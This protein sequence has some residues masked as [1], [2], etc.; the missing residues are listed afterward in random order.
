MKL[1]IVLLFLIFASALTA[2][3]AP[4]PGTQPRPEHR[5]QMMEMHTE[6]MKTMKADLNK[7][8]SALAEMKANLLTIKDTNELAR[9]RSNVD[10][11]ETM[12]GH[13]EQMQKHMEMMGP[14]MMGRSMD[15]PPSA[16]KPQ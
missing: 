8:K 16:T 4:V 9:W 2:Q 5:H 12:V 6:E 14:G 3:T 11:W 1:K 15:E 7:M 10:L 13:M